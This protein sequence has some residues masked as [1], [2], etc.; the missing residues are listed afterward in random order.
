[1]GMIAP[2]DSAFL[3]QEARE[4]PM[5]VGGLQLFHAPAAAG[6][7]YVGELYREL[8]NHTDVA[9]MFARR[10]RKPVESVGNFWWLQPRP[11]NITC[12]SYADHLEFGLMGCR[13]AVPKLQRL[14]DYLEESLQEVE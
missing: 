2:L 6:D 1:M 5:H 12:V 11:L 13:A 4:H 10:P 3:I 14:L 9:P 8:L 7:D